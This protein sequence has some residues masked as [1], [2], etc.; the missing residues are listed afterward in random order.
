MERSI[1]T[2]YA[3]KGSSHSW[4]WLADL[5]E[6]NGIVD[7]RFADTRAFTEELT[8]ETKAVLISGGDGHAIA[9]GIGPHGFSHLS[10]FIH[11]GGRYVGICAGAY[12]PL[13]SSVHPFD[14]FNLSTTKIENIECDPKRIEDGVPRRSVRYGSCAIIHPI[15][16]E[17]ELEASD[18]AFT[19][20]L[21]GGPVFRE[22]S[23]D[24]VLARYR[25]FTHYTEFQIEK[26]RAEAILLGKPAGVKA[27]HGH[28]D[29]VLLGPHL[30][31]PRYP[32]ANV[33]F[34]RFIGV[35]GAPAYPPTN[36]PLDAP[37]E[38]LERALADL[39]VAIL[40]LENRSFLVGNKMWDGSR[41]LELVNAMEGRIHTVGDTLANEVT[42]SLMRV[43]AEILK[44]KPESL[45]YADEG[46][47]RLIEATRIVIDNHFRV[48]RERRNR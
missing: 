18:V 33:H 45:L 30:E 9:S 27:K 28:G 12:L 16:G 36:A 1:L 42:Q 43:R 26:A 20:P 47:E 23:T 38:F 3:G 14:K 11:R 37:N 22:P 5:F 40:G 34:M 24:E 10:G 31:H 8:D 29:L 2:V 7:V 13:N 46:P 19:A 15:R 21:Y 41:F 39:K 44:A 48:L 32:Q 17:I 4:T 25:G 6:K 35:Q